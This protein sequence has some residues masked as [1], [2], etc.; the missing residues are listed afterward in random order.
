MTMSPAAAPALSVDELR[1]AAR[2]AGL[3]LPS[4][5]LDDDDLDAG[6]R[7]VV[8]VRGL[9]ARGLVRLDSADATPALTAPL[10]ALLAPLTRPSA[11]AELEFAVAGTVLRTVAADGP[12]GLLVMSEREPDVWL[13][14][15]SGQRLADALFGL[16][17]DGGGAEGGWCAVARR[18]GTSYVLQQVD[19]TAGDDPTAVVRP[20]LT[21]AA[22]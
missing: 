14:L 19:W 5:L 9:L 21:E 6:V 17:E 10:A 15:L 8:A 3:L 7:D 1:A 12:G 2:L 18:T 22:P 20:L 13:L 4:L 16:L 11:V